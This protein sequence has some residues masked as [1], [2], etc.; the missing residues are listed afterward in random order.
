MSRFA[1]DRDSRMPSPDL[2][3]DLIMRYPGAVLGLP[4]MDEWKGKDRFMSAFESADPGRG[5][6]EL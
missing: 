4:F 6:D 5:G 3:P 2:R 1:Q